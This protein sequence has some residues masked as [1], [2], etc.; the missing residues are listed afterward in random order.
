MPNPEIAKRIAPACPNL[1]VE[2]EYNSFSAEERRLSEERHR[3]ENETYPIMHRA[4]SSYTRDA[5]FLNLPRAEKESIGHV[6]V[7][8]AKTTEYYDL[9]KYL[10][11]GVWAYFAEAAYYYQKDRNTDE[12]KIF[13]NAK[14]FPHFRSI[15]KVFDTTS[16]E[17]AY[18]PYEPVLR[19]SNM[20][21]VEEGL[22]GHFPNANFTVLVEDQNNI[23][24]LSLNRS[25]ILHSIRPLIG[26]KPAVHPL[27]IDR[28]YKNGNN[29]EVQSVCSFD[30]FL[31][32]PSG[33]NIP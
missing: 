21:Y 14:C 11:E 4:F 6:Y 26:K 23:Y 7:E 8:A 27:Y 2:R 24:R 5:L 28:I 18:D 15:Q 25:N 32:K 13:T 17:T 12:F 19:L 33:K 16:C 1:E 29:L 10:G 20:T 31:R 9:S 3:E 22:H 30:H